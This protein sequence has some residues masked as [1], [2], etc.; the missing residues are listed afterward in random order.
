MDFFRE[1]LSGLDTYSPIKKLE[2]LIKTDVNNTNIRLGINHYLD[3]LVNMLIEKALIIRFSESGWSDDK[4]HSKLPLVNKIFLD[5]K[6][7]QIS[8]T[9]VD[10]FASKSTEW[11]IKLLEKNTTIKLSDFHHS[12]IKEKF[13]NQILLN[14]EVVND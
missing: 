4:R 10:L 13:I 3:E 9:D 6:Y 8:L 2:K 12:R 11:L 1:C 7:D 14:W 5:N